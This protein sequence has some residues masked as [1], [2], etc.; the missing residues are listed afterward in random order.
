MIEGL[1]PASALVTLDH[2]LIHL[3]L[4]MSHC[5]FLLCVVLREGLMESGQKAVFGSNERYITGAGLCQ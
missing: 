4:P 3:I 1:V 2:S 5:V